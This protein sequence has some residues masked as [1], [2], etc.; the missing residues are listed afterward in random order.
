VRRDA[1]APRV[2]CRDVW[3][4]PDHAVHADGVLIPVK[5]LV[6][7]RSIIREERAEI[8]Y[9]HVELAEHAVLLAEGLP[10][11]SLVP[12]SDRSRFANGGASVCLHPDFDALAWEADGC[13]PLVLTGPVLDAL[14][15]RLDRRADILGLPAP[16]VA[17]G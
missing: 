9:Y 4:S 15:Q 12:G 10:A 16:Q 3:L 17:T 13:A 7:G 11:E 14:R 2:P 5:H 8:T 6:N 1:F